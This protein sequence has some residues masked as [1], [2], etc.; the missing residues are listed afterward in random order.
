MRSIARVVVIWVSEAAGLLLMT[1]F[2]P[3]LR[4]DTWE[5]AVVVVAV[6]GLLNAIL[7]PFL[8]RIALPFLAF[9]FGVGALILNGL[10]VYLS[11]LVVYG[12]HAKGW[13]LV[14]VPI[15][16]AAINTAVSSILTIDDDAPYFRAVLARQAKRS[17]KSRATKPA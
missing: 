9:T 8:S 2:V 5:T 1:H 10:L 12:F 16:I 3:G 13:A 6:I 7:W 4:V 14:V 15:G 17:S 11:S